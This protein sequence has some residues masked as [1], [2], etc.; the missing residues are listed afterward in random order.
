MFS[1]FTSLG[2]DI[3]RQRFVA[4]ISILTCLFLLLPSVGNAHPG[5]TDS[6][7]GH[8]CRTNCEKWGYSYGEYHY[9]NGGSSSSSSTNSSSG[10]ST[11]SSSSGTSSST[12]S[13]T[14][15]SSSSSNSSTSTSVT[16]V[17]P[18][19][20]EK[21]VRANEHYKV[22][23]E[24]FNKGSYQSAIAELE[25]IYELGKE[26][27]K[28]ETLL[29]QALSSIYQLAEEAVNQEEF[30]VAKEH[31]D[32]IQS[33][34]RTTNSLKEKVEVLLGKMELQEKV[35]DL[36]SKASSSRDKKEYSEALQYIKEAEEISDSAKITAFHDETLDLLLSDAQEALDKQQYSD[37]EVFY[38]I[39]IANEESTKLVEE[40]EKKLNNIY[41]MIAIQENFGIES[42]NLNGNSLFTHLLKVENE[43]PYNEKVVDD[44]ISSLVEDAKEAM[45]FIFNMNIKELF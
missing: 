23:N 45:K 39:L 33:Y 9:H 44:L 22:A 11:N 42:E 12:S 29:K 17:K 18:V 8:T 16:Q 28:T 20:D 7:G 31:L 24:Y 5:R 4:F 6:N 21:Q 37:A 19:V 30:T 40:Y 10:T 26:D 34:N 1:I 15:T 3:V 13:S 41:T 14:S 36:L 35:N 27:S 43:T 25:K 32:F 38:K 2:G